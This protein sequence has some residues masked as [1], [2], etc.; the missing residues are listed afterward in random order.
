ME[1]EVKWHFP[2]LSPGPIILTVPLSNEKNPDCAY[3]VT[4]TNEKI[5]DVLD[6]SLIV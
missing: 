4:E 3:F 2:K 1:N 6:I 5:P